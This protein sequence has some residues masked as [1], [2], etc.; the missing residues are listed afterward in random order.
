[1]WKSLIVGV[2]LIA[3]TA[4]AVHAQTGSQTNVP[5][6]PSAPGNFQVFFGFDQ[7]TLTPDAKRVVA[8]AAAEFQRS[9]AARI[10]TTGHTDTSGSAE[11]NMR[12]SQR[13]ADAVARELVRLGVPQGVI[14]T[15]ARGESDLLVPTKDGVR[16]PRNR[17][18]EIE[19]PRPPAQPRPVAAAPAPAPAKPAEK[20]PEPLKWAFGLGGFYGYNL[21]ETDEDD[22]LTSHLV[23]GEARIAYYVTPNIPVSVEQAVFNTI[24][25]SSD[26]GWGGRSVVGIDFQ[27]NFGGWRPY[28]GANVGGVYGKGVQDSFVA[29]PEIGFEVDFSRRWFMYAKAAYDVVFRNDI[30]DGIIIGGLGAGYRF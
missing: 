19:I 1:M 30:E 29:G 26:D 15:V 20:A 22:D 28:I 6:R 2:S 27:G 10:T 14:T 13:R 24:D 18:V 7:A 17:R 21:K 4:P 16:E 3:L 11:Y 23:G 12:L 8:D 25:T 9:G 5:D